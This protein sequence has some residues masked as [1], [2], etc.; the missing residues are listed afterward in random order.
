MR[1]D[2]KNKTIAL[3]EGDKIWVSSGDHK[4]EISSLSPGNL[5]VSSILKYRH[6]DGKAF[7]TSEAAEDYKRTVQGCECFNGIRIDSTE[8]RIIVSDGLGAGRVHFS[9]TGGG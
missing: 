3:N 9:I 6:P 7:P 5:V 2:K 8:H 4:V 1:F